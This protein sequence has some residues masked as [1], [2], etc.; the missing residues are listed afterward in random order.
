[1]RKIM[2]R[3]PATSALVLALAALPALA[4]DERALTRASVSSAGAAG[5]GPSFN[6][7]LSLSGRFVLF[8]S[9]ATNLVANDANGALADVFL[10][11]RRRN[12]TTLVSVSSQGEQG[13]QASDA[14]FLSLDGRYA[15]FQSLASNLV[16]GDTNGFCDVFLRDLWRGRTTRISVGADGVQGNDCSFA[17][18]L[19]ATGRF[20]LVNSWA[21]NLVPGIPAGGSNLLTFD[22]ASGRITVETVGPAGEPSNAAAPARVSGGITFDGRYVAFHTP[23]SN[24]IAGD[25][26]GAVQDVF[27]RDRRTGRTELVSV[28]ANGGAAD[29]ASAFQD[30]SEDGRLV[31]F[32]STAA[33]LVAE[34][35]TPGSRH[36]YLRDMRARRTVRLDRALGGGEPNGV[37]G[38]VASMSLSKRYV[39]FN[40]IASD[41]V[42]NDRNGFADSFVLDRFTGRTRLV[43]LSADGTQGNA[44]V[45]GQFGGIAPGGN[46]VSFVSAADNLVPG[47]VAG[48]ID[49][50]V[51]PQAAPLPR[52][53]SATLRAATAGAKRWN[54]AAAMRSLG[55][56]AGGW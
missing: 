5:N 41:L 21:S 45:F 35:T 12:L 29:G 47:D 46:V 23:A 24:L 19:S 6:P 34:A 20:V 4:D 30:I 31:L 48:T 18:G 10:R 16:A 7:E 25:G 53:A 38:T 17:S 56:E 22:R 27:R 39:F 11:D 28:A 36:L 44:H 33:N 9:V 42:A 50:F 54:A 32:A 2:S 3:L 1:M 13:N 8:N 52:A 37:V 55:R 26:N 14:T 49:V 51:G 43:S 15:L 40:S